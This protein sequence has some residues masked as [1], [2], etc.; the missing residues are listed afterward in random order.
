MSRLSIFPERS[1]T[2]D[3]DGPQPVLVIDEPKRIQL[4][5]DRRGIAFEQW[6]AAKALTQGL[7][8]DTILAAYQAE[9]ARIQAKGGYQTVDAIRMT[10][11]HPDR[12]ALRLKFLSEH[13]HA[14]DEVRF[15]VEGQGLFSLHIGAEVLVTLCERGDLISV[16][17]GTRHWFDMGHAP[18]FCA[19]RFF[20]NPQG[21]V[22]D[23]T[24]DAI[25]SR[26][27]RLD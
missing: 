16:P 3:A 9:V 22:A 18:C 26:F 23:F 15:F 12:D 10:P 21:W 11:D 25:S 1:I 17:A 7:E 24:G 19:L 6:P 27:P 5:L 8:Q 2:E 4:E 13:T 20:N 14:E